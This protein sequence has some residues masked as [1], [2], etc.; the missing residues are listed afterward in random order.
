MDGNPKFA[1]LYFFDS[2]HELE[3]RLQ[4]VSSLK[5]EILEQLQSCLHRVNPYIKDIK[6]ALEVV[7][8]APECRL[9]LSNNVKL[10]PKEAHPRTYNLP[11]GS[12]VAVLLPGDQLGDLDV[13]L[14]N[15]CGNLQRINAVH[16]SYDALHYVLLLPT[17]QDGFKPGISMQKGNEK[18]SI[19]QFYAFQLQVRKN[20]FNILLR[21]H[22]LTQ[23]YITDQYAKVERARL[24]WAHLNQKTIK[25]EKYRG[26]LD[27]YDNGDIAAAGKRFILPPSITYS[28]RWYVE[29][30]QDGM[31]IVKHTVKPDIF[32]TF[33]CNPKWPEITK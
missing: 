11:T 6:V 17:G 20:S 31:T 7:K 28:P 9:I 5:P 12:E 1:Q 18:V 3:N 2:E 25:A 26:L 33:T 24:T 13:V 14:Q 16:R 21:G 19:M 4:H 32:V 23:Q 27:A 29:R 30:Y 10:Q 22:R 8:D 15:R